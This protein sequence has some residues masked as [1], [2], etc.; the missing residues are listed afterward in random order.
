M[1]VRVRVC[2]FGNVLVGFLHCAV[3]HYNNRSRDRL[4]HFCLYERARLQNKF[5]NS[6]HTHTHTRTTIHTHYE[7]IHTLSAYMYMCVSIH[8]SVYMPF[9][10]RSCYLCL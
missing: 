4:C 1:C 6:I 7:T 9:R 2:H 3:Y 10:E 5:E 8:M